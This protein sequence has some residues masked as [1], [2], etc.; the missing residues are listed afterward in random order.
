MSPC[1]IQLKLNNMTSAESIVFATEMCCWFIL[2]LVVG[3]TPLQL[4]CLSCSN[5]VVMIHMQL[6]HASFS[7]IRCQ[8]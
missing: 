2:H 7:S 6:E 5:S 8:L 1:H 3:R 4:W